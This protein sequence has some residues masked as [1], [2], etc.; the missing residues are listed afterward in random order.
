M[1][2][3]L[4]WQNRAMISTPWLCSET[5]KS[6]VREEPESMRQR[7]QCHGNH[8]NHT[9][10]VMNSISSLPPYTLSPR[11]PAPHPRQNLVMFFQYWLIHWKDVYIYSFSP[12]ENGPR[13]SFCLQVTRGQGWVVL[14][15]ET[16]HLVTSC[17]VHNNSA[18]EEEKVRH[19]SYVEIIQVK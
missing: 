11:P 13:S 2:R 5:L 15:G 10:L 12:P 16:F 6:Q 4:L 18:E 9:V 19:N 7:C 8:G 1:G 14:R 17:A 3:T